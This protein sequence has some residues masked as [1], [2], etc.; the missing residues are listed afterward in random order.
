MVMRIV[1]AVLFSLLITLAACGGGALFDR[2]GS[3]EA[4][5]ERGQRLFT[6]HCSA[7][8]TTTAGANL[9][10]PSLAGIASTAETR[11]AGVNAAEYL[12]LA[13][14]EPGAYVV[15][16]FA[17]MMPRNFGQRLKRDELDALTAYLLT[18]E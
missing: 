8:H 18:L 3:A 16:G 6:Q 10:G 5:L 1:P 13:I 17:D 14:L 15:E 4:R 7:C 2:T 11:I 9:V 12:E